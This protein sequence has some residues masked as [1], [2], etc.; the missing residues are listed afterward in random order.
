MNSVPPVRNLRVFSSWPRLLGVLLVAALLLGPSC[1]CS[2][3]DGT[4]TPRS[5]ND[6]DEEGEILDGLVCTNGTWIEPDVW[7]GDAANDVDDNVDDDAEDVIVDEDVPMPDD[8]GTEEDVECE[9]ESHREFCER[10]DVECGSFV[11]LDNCENERIVHCGAFE[12]F[13]CESPEICA[14]ASDD[15]ELET[16]Q[17]ACP[18]LDDD[19]PESDI[20]AYADAE[21]GTVDAEELCGGWAEYGDVDCGDCAEDGV[22]CGSDLD[23]ICG[24]PCDIEGA[25][26]AEGQADPDNPCAVCDP[27]E[28]DDA[29]SPAPDDTEC[30]D[31]GICSDGEC[32]C[33]AGTEECDGEC[34][35][36]DTNREHCGSCDSACDDD[37]VC[38]D[39]ECEEGCPEELSMCDGECVDQESDDDHC[40]ACGDECTTNVDGATAFCEDGEC[41]EEC[42]GEHHEVCDEQ[43]VD[44]QTD[45]NHCG[46]CDEACAIN[47][48]CNNGSCQNV[49]GGC[50]DDGD[51]PG[52]FYCCNDECIPN[53]V[54]CQDG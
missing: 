2:S 15:D 27:D 8:S 10:Y 49:A 22:D 26:Y 18:S 43:C 19:E 46:E 14:H 3:D 30:G 33:E 34:V 31:E 47:Q 20:C 39:G 41:I 28:A 5:G 29:F 7:D 42:P 50:E 37:Q 54:N 1:T 51:C 23:N 36:L 13:Q 48:N 25:C 32:V 17:C 16:N 21:C 9:A 40:G 6:C 4:A 12:Q 35:D 24:C 45:R 44:L 52:P 38:S 11:G 53:A